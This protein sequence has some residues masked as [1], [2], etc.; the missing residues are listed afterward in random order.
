MERFRIRTRYQRERFA[1]A[2][3]GELKNSQDPK[4]AA[5][6]EC[7][8]YVLSAPIDLVNGAVLKLLREHADL[9]AALEL[10]VS[11]K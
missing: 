4:V 1:V 8:V 9:K 10:E 7:I 5:L 3:A 2:L 6:G 11:S